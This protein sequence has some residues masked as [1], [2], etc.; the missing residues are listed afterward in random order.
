[1]KNIAII[2]KPHGDRVRPLLGEI[3]HFLSEHGVR[4][5]K[6]KRTAEALGER[7]FNTDDEIREQADLVI[8]LGGDGTLI[9]AVRLLGMKETP[10]LGINLGRLGFLTETR[11]SDAIPAIKSVLDGDYRMER[12]M[13]LHSHLLEDDEKVLEI[14]VLNDLVI[15]KSDVARIIEMSLYINKVLVN[16]Y[17][18]D[19]LI[20]ATPTGS[21]A[22]SLAA[23][24][25]IVHPGLESM[26][27]TPICPQGL[28]NRP[29]VISDDSE[30]EIRIKTRNERVSITFDGQV[31]RQLDT[32]KTIKVKKASSYTHII[33]PKDKNYYALIREKL[34]WGGV[35]C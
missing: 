8:V 17:R 25:P 14:D 15:N 2:A 31:Y 27:I 28:S 21:T 12:R 20:V 4:I 33:V 18:A 24:G 13:K 22:Y 29:I 10:I 26:I 11:A 6:A 35:Q 19:G 7:E 5:L 34:G 1:M 16:E 23:G 32:E 30:I 3:T 9:S